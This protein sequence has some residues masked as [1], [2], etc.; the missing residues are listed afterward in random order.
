MHLKE[1]IIRGV[2]H[3]GLAFIEVL[4]P[5]PTYN[6]INTKAWYDGGDR[7]DPDTGKPRPRVYR[8]EEFFNPR[9]DSLDEEPEKMRVALTRALELGDQIPIGVFY[10]NENESTFRERLYR[11]MPFYLE[12]PPAKQRI[13]DENGIS[14]ALMEKLL[15]ELKTT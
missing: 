7:L 4:Q 11:R 5:C 14:I 12:R 15:G 10:Q 2:K 3:K 6:D 13:S 1:T 8:L 9:V